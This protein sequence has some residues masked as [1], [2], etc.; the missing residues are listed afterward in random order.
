[1]VTRHGT[2]TTLRSYQPSETLSKRFGDAKVL[3][4]P[5]HELEPTDANREVFKQTLLKVTLPGLSLPEI[6]GIVFDKASQ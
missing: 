4:H 6:M 3:A 2:A 1:M 5:V